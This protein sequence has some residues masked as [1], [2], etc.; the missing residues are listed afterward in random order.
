MGQRLK[1]LGA[2]IA[3]LVI[4]GALKMTDT[5]IDLNNT[6]NDLVEDVETNSQAMD[7]ILFQFA[8]HRVD[9]QDSHRALHEFAAS[10]V[11]D[12]PHVTHPSVPGIPESLDK[13]C[14]PFLPSPGDTQVTTTHP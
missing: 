6:V 7:C 11:G 13:A 9:N 10:V 3:V 12:A 4:I 5:I 8:E 14:D 1:W 2:F